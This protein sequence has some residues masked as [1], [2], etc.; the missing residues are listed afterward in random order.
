MLM[1]PAQT[2]DVDRA[3]IHPNVL[4]DSGR[5]SEAKEGLVDQIEYV[6]HFSRVLFGPVPGAICLGDE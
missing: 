3:V 6:V 4:T 2:I 1:E 5:L